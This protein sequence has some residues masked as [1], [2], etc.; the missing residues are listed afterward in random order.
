MD[1]DFG[2][3]EEQRQV[4]AAVRHWVAE[5]AGPESAGFEEKKE[6]PRDLFR[7]LGE[8]GLA[9]IS[10]D[11]R[12]GGGGQPYLTYLLVLEEIATGFLS[13]AVTV[14]VHHLAASGIHAFGS[15]DLQQAYL[16][17][18][19]SADWLGAYA[20]SEASSGSDAASLRTRA[21]RTPAGYVLDGSKRFITPGGEAELYKVMARNGGG[22]PEGVAPFAIQR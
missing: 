22:G 6:F 2:L 11:E 5:K 16:P 13:L 3:S 21:E 18:L 10:Y 4:V 8:M 14:S 1:R 15:D 20:L 9:G 17:R 12:Y 7:Q 19:F